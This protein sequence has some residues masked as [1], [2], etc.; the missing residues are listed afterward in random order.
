MPETHFRVRWPDGGVEVCYSPSTIIKQFFVLGRPYALDD[1][2]DIS[3]CALHAASERVREEY[4][5]GC[6]RAMAQ[7]DAIEA[8]AKTQPPDGAP[9]LVEAF[10]R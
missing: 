6:S 10:S 1:F 7:L 5:M 9:V 3:R 2:L 8:R 4:G